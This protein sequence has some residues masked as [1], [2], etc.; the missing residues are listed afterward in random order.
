M[1]LLECLAT[2]AKKLELSDEQI[3]VLHCFNRAIL[4]KLG[5]RTAYAIIA[6]LVDRYGLDDSPDAPT[7]GAQ[8]VKKGILTPAEGYLFAEGYLLNAEK[9]KEHAASNGEDAEAAAFDGKA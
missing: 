8:L 2:T 1:E 9:T 5:I 7:Y 4:G 6:D 3:L